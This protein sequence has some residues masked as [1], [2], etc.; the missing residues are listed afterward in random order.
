MP[1]YKQHISC[2]FLCSFLI[3]VCFSFGP[4]SLA[5]VIEWS[6]CTLLGSLF[7]DIDIKSKGQFIFYALFS[8]LLFYMIALQK[9]VYVSLLA[10]LSCIPILSKHRGIFHNFWF[11]ATLVI[12]LLALVKY[13]Y[14]GYYTLISYDAFFFMIGVFSHLLLDKGFL[15]TLKL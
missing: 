2:G 3:L 14:P 1:G 9:W 13:S 15:K 8:V 5:S 12:V 10:M 4:F 11:V 7:P 6:L